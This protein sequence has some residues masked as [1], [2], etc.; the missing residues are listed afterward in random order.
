MHL[1]TH[2][3]DRIEVEDGKIFRVLMAEYDKHG[4]HSAI[5]VY[6]ENEDGESWERNLYHSI[7]G[8]SCV[9]FP[10]LPFNENRN[11]YYA[12]DPGPAEIED[13]IQRR[14][15]FLGGGSSFAAGPDFEAI[16]RLYP[17]F[18]YVINKHNFSD[19]RDLMDKFLVWKKHPEVEFLLAA[20]FEKIAM[21]GNF[22]RMTEKHR[23]ELCAFM[24]KNPDYRI[25]ELRELKECFNFKNPDLYFEYIN[26]IPGYIRHSHSTAIDFELF[27]Y[28]KKQCAKTPGQEP[29]GAARLY[30]DYARMASRLNHDIKDVYWRYPSDFFQK[31][32]ELTRQIEQME[33]A[34]RIA[35]EAAEEAELK[36]RQATLEKI[37]A[38][39]LPYNAELSGYRVFVSTDLDEWK[40]QAKVLHQ[41]IVAAG[42]YQ[43]MAKGEKVLVFIQKENEPVAT[44][45]IFPDGRIGQFYADE[46]DRSNCLPSDDVRKVLDEWML[47][48]PKKLF[49]TTKNK[50]K[51]TEAAQ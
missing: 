29:Y 18:Q 37:C 5:D 42:Y 51:E 24:R 17:S 28:L 19:T 27:C 31:H 49:K 30:Q 15:R 26:T 6:K 34:E 7:W 10:D 41:C 47:T 23:K 21:N 44:A 39:F 20:G 13:W 14:T 45:E 11:G 35:R 12:Y 38:R 43:K 22:W 40:R 2:W 8:G 36:K 16:T 46:L 25:L 33:E 1:P 50:K 9:A 48:V 32:D 4:E 3:S